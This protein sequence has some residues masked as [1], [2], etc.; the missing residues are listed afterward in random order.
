MTTIV[1][2]WIRGDRIGKHAFRFLFGYQS[3][4]KSDKCTMATVVHP[5]L[6]INAFTRPSALALNEF[7]LGIEIENL[8]PSSDVIL[9]QISSLS[10]TWLV[11][12][13]DQPALDESTCRLGA[14]QTLFVYF[15]FIRSPEAVAATDPARTPEMI[16]TSAIE[17]LILGR[18]SVALNAPDLTLRVSSLSSSLSS[19]FTLYLTDDVD[20]ALFWEV[21][22]T[23]QPTQGHHYIIGI[24][25]GLQA[26]LQLQARLGAIAGSSQ[27]AAGRAL[28]A[29]T[30]REKKALVA[31]LLK[32][33]QKDVS[34][35]RLIIETSNTITHDFKNGECVVP[36]TIHLRNSSSVN[37]AKYLLEIF[38]SNPAH[39]ETPTPVDSTDLA[40]LGTTFATG[41]LATEAEASVTLLACFPRPGVYDVSRWRLSVSLEVAAAA[42]GVA[43][44]SREE[45]PP[46][47]G[48]YV[49]TPNLPHWVTILQKSMVSKRKA[50]AQSAPPPS[51]KRLAD[52]YIDE[53]ASDD[54]DSDNAAGSQNGDFNDVEL[55]GPEDEDEDDAE[56]VDDGEL[57]DEDEEGGEAA[58]RPRAKKDGNALYRA[59]TS[60]EIHMLKETTDLFKSNLFKMQID[61][62]L[63]EVRIDYTKMSPLE[64]ALHK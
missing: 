60:D 10:P 4:D 14:R 20:L 42:A 41:T 22:D 39:S 12:P 7:V 64:K 28:Y 27:A 2:V 30:V 50:V 36:V 3:E 56:E 23:P 26:P 1:P 9:R 55:D 16:T 62:L 59:P 53:S 13:I 18:D 33:R 25:L 29:E 40:W 37:I 35:V 34:P 58:S 38:S 47:A 57:E 6:R 54:E 49:Q 31:S 63:G 51:K 44:V 32:A 5:S 8:Q 45:G 15:R 21:P 19:L 52:P 43:A 61:E 11:Q 46:P 48:N 17:N 24:N